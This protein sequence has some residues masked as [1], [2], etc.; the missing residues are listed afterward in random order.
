MHG[1]SQKKKKKKKRERER[2]MNVTSNCIHLFTLILPL[3]SYK[4]P[5]F[6]LLILCGVSFPTALPFVSLMFLS[7]R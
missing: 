7:G 6:I 1:H 2:E 5:A 3:S 4:Q